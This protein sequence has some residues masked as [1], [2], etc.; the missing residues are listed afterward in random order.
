MT[1]KS[2][3]VG[4]RLSAARLQKCVRAAANDSARVVFLEPPD[5]RNLAGELT[6]RQ[7]LK[8]LQ[9]GQLVGRPVLDEHA[10]WRFQMWRHAVGLTVF[11][12]AAA[13]VSGARIEQI[14]VLG[15]EAG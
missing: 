4:I 12:D 6:Y 10:H 1:G 13:K 14:V 7:V 9:D 3:V 15:I 2:K 5:R 8:C 11:V